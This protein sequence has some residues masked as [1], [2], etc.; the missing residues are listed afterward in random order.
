VD[1]EPTCRCWKAVSQ[2]NYF[3]VASFTLPAFEEITS[4][5]AGMAALLRRVKG[6]VPDFIRCTQKYADDF[7][8]ELL[9]SLTGNSLP[10]FRQ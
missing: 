2:P 3:A 8:V 4:A 6:V 10:C 7:R 9:S 1:R 5:L